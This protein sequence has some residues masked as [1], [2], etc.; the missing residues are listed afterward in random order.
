MKLLFLC[1]ELFFLSVIAY[2]YE[3]GMDFNLQDKSVSLDI[4]VYSS[5]YFEAFS[6][7]W[8]RRSFR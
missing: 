1:W 2:V 4:E 6:W 7:A 8:V 5:V 3:K